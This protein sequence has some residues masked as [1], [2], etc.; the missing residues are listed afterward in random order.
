MFIITATIRQ[1]AVRARVFVHVCACK[2][3]AL[4]TAE[5]LQTLTHQ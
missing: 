5:G 4:R 2:H 3:A 1:E